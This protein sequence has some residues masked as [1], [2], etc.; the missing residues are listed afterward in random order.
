MDYFYSTHIHGT[1]FT[2]DGDEAS[3]LVQVMRKKAGEEIRIVDGLGTAYDARIDALSRNSASGTIL[4]THPRHNESP[5]DVTIAVGLLKNP[6]KFDFLVEKVTELGVREIIPLLTARTIASH[7][8]AERWQKLALAAMKQ[9]GRSF[10]PKVHELMTIAD[11]LADAKS[12]DKKLI[13]HEQADPAALRSGG[14][15]AVR[16]AI[17]LIGPEGGFTP[18]EK[19]QAEQAGYAHWYLGDRRLRAETAAI[20]AA[21]MALLET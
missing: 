15:G 9:S 14:F 21:A 6:S 5:R 10:L 12:Y 18:E 2:I 8:K 19:A 3:H 20:V 4:A 11:L 16:S 17:I 1:S 7:A 13:A